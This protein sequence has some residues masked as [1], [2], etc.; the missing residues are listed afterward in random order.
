MSR[1]AIWIVD[2]ARCGDAVRD[3]GGA[4]PDIAETAARGR[5]EASAD[6][7]HLVLRLL[8]MA[9]IGR[10]AACQPFT[11]GRFGKPVLPGGEAVFSLSHSA[12]HAL[13]AIADE[14]PIGVDLEHVRPRQLGAAR[15]AKLEAIALALAGPLPDAPEMRLTQAWTRLEATAK[16]TGEGIGR[17]L[18]QLGARPRAPETSID[19]AAT[20]RAYLARTSLK[21][22]DL[23]IADDIRAAIALGRSCQPGDARWLP[24][25]REEIAAVVRPSE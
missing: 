7:G 19:V 10:R 4:F 25:T 22:V 11:R 8:L 9:R 1:T 13:I 21:V 12:A 18:E 2:C 16:A 6:I 24:A 14:G 17:L 15:R 3:L 23:A 20:A 5:G